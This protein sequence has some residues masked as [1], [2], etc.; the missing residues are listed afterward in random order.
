LTWEMLV[1]FLFG[2]PVVVYL[3]GSLRSNNRRT[4]P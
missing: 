3:F 4:G 2:P 1:V